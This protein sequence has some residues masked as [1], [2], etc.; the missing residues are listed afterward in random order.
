MFIALRILSY[1]APSGAACKLGRPDQIALL[2]SAEL[3][4]AQVYKHCAPPEHF[5]AKSSP[6]DFCAKRSRNSS[7]RVHPVTRFKVLGEC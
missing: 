3:I 2:R 4:K 1:F 6:T 7:T 5:A